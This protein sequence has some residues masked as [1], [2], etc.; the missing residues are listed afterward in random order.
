MAPSSRPPP[1][2]DDSMVDM[3]HHLFE[4]M[5]QEVAEVSHDLAA[6][7]EGAIRARDGRGDAP[8][9]SLLLRTVIEALNLLSNAAQPFTGEEEDE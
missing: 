9:S 7:V 6:R 2:A 8:F 4:A 3:V 1:T 5:R